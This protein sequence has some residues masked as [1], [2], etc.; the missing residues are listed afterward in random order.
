MSLKYYEK[1]YFKIW[2]CV[3]TN[4]EIFI[5]KSLALNFSLYRSIEA[6]NMDRAKCLET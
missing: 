2:N 3:D 5:T 1:C 4:F 6:V